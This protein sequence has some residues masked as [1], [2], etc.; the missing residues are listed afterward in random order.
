MA[1]RQC[2]PLLVGFALA[3]AA[4]AQ[5][6]PRSV[7]PE[8][9]AKYWVLIESTLEA[10]VPLGGKGMDQPGC[11]TV[12]FVVE[13]NGKASHIKVQKVVP[14]GDLGSVAASAVASLELEPTIVNAG[15]DRVFS[16]LIFPFNLPPDP[17]ARKEVMQ[18]CV[19]EPLRWSD[20]AARTDA[21]PAS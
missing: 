16:S 4:H 3:H 18:R 12:S 9:L 15:R 2:V 11:A 10:S 6:V 17:A 13:R 20:P 7:T 19:I 21:K 1:I 5:D 8:T 14:P